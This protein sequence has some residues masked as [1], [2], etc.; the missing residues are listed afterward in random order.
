MPKSYSSLI[1]KIISRNTCVCAIKISGDLGCW[2]MN[3]KYKG[4]ILEDVNIYNVSIQY[5]PDKS[6]IYLYRLKENGDLVDVE[7][8][9]PTFQSN[10]FQIESGSFHSC[11]LKNTTLVSSGGQLGC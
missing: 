8:V 6:R 3:E 4:L 9:P 5:D 10:I 2:D 1:K 11:V 7:N